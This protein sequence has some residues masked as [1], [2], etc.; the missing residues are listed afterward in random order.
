VPFAC[1]TCLYKGLLLKN[2]RKAFF[3][4]DLLLLFPATSSNRYWVLKQSS[5]KCSLHTYAF[6]SFFG[7]NLSSR[8]S[9]SNH[10]FGNFL[11]FLGKLRKVTPLS[12]SFLV[13]VLQPGP[14]FLAQLNLEQKRRAL[15]FEL[16]AY[17]DGM[18]SRICGLAFKILSKWWLPV[19]NFSLL[20]DWDRIHFRS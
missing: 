2:C 16:C 18:T 12:L 8:R 20:F 11:F 14:N 1:N 7:M 4:N 3:F 6:S 17:S 9:C 19:S 10:F 5:V 15:A 13:P